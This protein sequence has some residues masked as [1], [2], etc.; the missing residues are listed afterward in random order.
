[1]SEL[2]RFTSALTLTC[3]ALVNGCS[4]HSQRPD[5]QAGAAPGTS[6]NTSATGTSAPVPARGSLPTPEPT[7][8][9][10][11][12]GSA[13]AA[14]L[15]LDSEGSYLLTGNGAFRLLPGRAPERWNL[16]LGVSP[17]LKGEHFLYFGDGAFRQV[18]KRGGEPTIL[19]A[20]AGEPQRIVTSGERFAWVTRSEGGGYTIQTLHGAGVQ[21]VHATDRYVVAL[22]M[23]DELVF[24][25]EQEKGTNWRLGVVQ[26]SGGAPRYSTMKTGRTPAMLAAAGDLFYYDGPSFTVRRASPDLTRE[27]VVA[28]DV[29]CSPIAVSKHVY[30]AQPAGL[31]E[32][33]FDGGIRRALPLKRRGAITAVSATAARLTW[34]LDTGRDQLAVETIPLSGED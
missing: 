23:Q 17:A 18:P 20:A 5:Q 6:V 15:A 2:R 25:A 27:H 7:T 21:L 19:A 30:C 1:V 29:I 8:L 26:V 24:F 28:R 12:G 11:T 4:C 34:L 22:A 3:A 13:Y 31:L 16:D 10:D 33:G 14:T 9:L 32:I